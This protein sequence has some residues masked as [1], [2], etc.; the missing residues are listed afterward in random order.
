MSKLRAFLFQPQDET[1]LDYTEGS[2]LADA[3]KENLSSDQDREKTTAH[4]TTPLNTSLSQASMEKD[5]RECPQTPI[6]RLPLAALIAGGDQT[7]HS[8][9]ESI[10]VE[11]VLWN[12]SQHSDD[13]DGSQG[14]RN[15]K[16]G[17][18]RAHSSSPLSSPNQSRRSL[19]KETHKIEKVPTSLET[20]QADPVYDLWSR[21][22]LASDKPSP[23]THA[24]TGL[25]SLHS[26]SPQTPTT[27][28]QGRESIK[29]RRSY[30]CNV[31]WPTS[32]TKRRKLCHSSSNQEATGVHANHEHGSQAKGNSKMARVSLL[33]EHIQNRLA[34]SNTQGEDDKSGIDPS[35]LLPLVER[36]SFG[37]SASA[38]SPRASDLDGQDLETEPAHLLE[39]VDQDTALI[40]GQSQPPLS[41]NV[42]IADATEYEHEESSPESGHNQEY[43]EEDEDRLID[44]E[45]ALMRVGEEAEITASGMGPL[46]PPCNS[47]ANPQSKAAPDPGKNKESLAQ[48]ATIHSVQGDVFEEQQSSPYQ[49]S[50]K[51]SS[52]G[53]DEFDDEDDSETFAADLEDIVAKYDATPQ[54]QVQQLTNRI[55]SNA[56]ISNKPRSA[57]FGTNVSSNV[58]RPLVESGIK[59]GAISDEEFGE[60]FDFENIIAQCEEASQ[61]THSASQVQSSVCTRTFGPSI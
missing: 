54:P 33:V 9:V 56:R 29:L 51:D 43:D 13:P 14:R 26:S 60:D 17:T 11:R 46:I 37:T 18:K 57:T 21:Y 19:T 58:Q 36:A 8:G 20:P 2:G 38:S 7:K 35:T 45:T 28:W 52:P 59:S 23:T 27:H 1:Q 22:S 30:S 32:A 16:R 10:P 42:G 55:S 47:V 53:L 31:E 5:T 49:C 44:W 48:L 50:P 3:A 41:V 40:I 25:P 12:H 24:D 4:Q 61:K 34:R 39:H 15:I 6:G